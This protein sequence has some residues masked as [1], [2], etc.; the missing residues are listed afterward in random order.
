MTTKVEF[1]SLLRDVTGAAEIELS[2][3]DGATVGD[4]LA[5]LYALHPAL[6]EWD[7]RLLLA[8]DLDY[9]ERTHTIREGEI[10]SVMPPVQG[11]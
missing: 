1:Y 9:A 7:G 8:A 2:L 6:A 10:I 3:P 11:G 4:M 5:A